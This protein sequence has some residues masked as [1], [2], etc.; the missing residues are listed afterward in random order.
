MS[1][2]LFRRWNAILTRIEDLA[3]LLVSREVFRRAQEAWGRT[4]ANQYLATD[5]AN[6]M[7]NNYVAY[8]ATAIRRIAEPPNRRWEVIS[9]AV[10]LHELAANNQLLTR[11]RFVAGYKRKIV[12]ERFANRDFDRLIGRAGARLFPRNVI[13]KDIRRLKRAVKP[14][15]SLVD[16]VIGHT[17]EKRFR[18]KVFYRD[19]NASIDTIAELFQKYNQ[20]ITG[21]KPSLEHEHLVD[22]EDDRRKIWP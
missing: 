14:V 4:A 22:V 5:L 18:T 11:E 1:A 16:K 8:A 2:T 12:R 20:L 3:Q 9:M 7:A 15:K 21:S 10:L 19:L 6:W 13:N 17:Q